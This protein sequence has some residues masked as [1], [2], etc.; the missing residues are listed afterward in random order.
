MGFNSAFKG[1]IH[2]DFP[3]QQWLQEHASMLRY[4]YISCLVASTM[5]TVSVSGH[6]EL[7]LV[8]YRRL[9]GEVILTFCVL[10][11]MGYKGRA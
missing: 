6:A 11:Y 10:K 5:H 7:A 3:L 2:I 4:S 1:L 9:L 8:S